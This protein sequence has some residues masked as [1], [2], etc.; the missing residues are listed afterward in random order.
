M[1]V[2]QPLYLGGLP[3]EVGDK[4]AKDWHIRSKASFQ[5]CFNEVWINYKRID[6]LKALKK[7]K[8]SAG[9]NNFA[10]EHPKVNLIL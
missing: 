10:A 6:F 2:A 3:K 5:G 7:E 9:C 8:I 4:A 1:D